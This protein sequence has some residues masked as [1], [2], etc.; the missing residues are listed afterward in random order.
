[1]LSVFDLNFS[2]IPGTGGEKTFPSK[3]KGIGMRKLDGAL[4]EEQL[5]DINLVMHHLDF[6][7]KRTCLCTALSI[8]PHYEG[9]FRTSWCKQLVHDPIS[10]R[11]STVVVSFQL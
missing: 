3:M 4:D 2:I 11:Y 9:S 1:M 8:M 5:S 7:Q 6:R 10:L